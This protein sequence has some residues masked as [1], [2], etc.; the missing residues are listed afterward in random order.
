MNW[1]VQSSAVDFLHLLLV[2][3]DHLIRTY[4]IRARLSISIHD[5]VRYLV[6]EPDAPRLALALHLSNLFARA[7][8]V[9]KLS[10]DDLPLS[11]AFFSA[12]DVDQVQ[13]KEP[14]DDCLSPSCPRGLTS[15]FG[16]PLG[17]SLN[18]EECLKRTGGSLEK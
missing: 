15:K 17:E 13:R 14:T 18:I 12:V 3:M 16:I 2:Q 6:A 7:M 9:H 11:V 5:E 4:K 10:M 1:V 8:F